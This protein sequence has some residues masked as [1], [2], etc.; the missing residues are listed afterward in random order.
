MK[1]G[2]E[3]M[4]FTIRK[5]AISIIV[6]LL[7]FMGN[8]NGL[9]ASNNQPS[10][11]FQV[12]P[13]QSVIVKPVNENARGNLD[14]S[15]IPKGK[16]TNTFRDPIDVVFIFDKSGSMDANRMK[17]AK[18]AMKVA[19]DYFIENAHY[20]DRFALVPFSS[21]VELNNVVSFDPKWTPQ[22]S[23]QEIN[24]KVQNL[25][26]LGGTNYTSSFEKASEIL[27]AGSN[28]KYIIFLTD[29]E[30]TV[31]KN[32]EKYACK[33][34][35]SSTCE[36]PV[37]Q[38]LYGSNPS[39]SK[40][41]AYTNSNFST[42]S[43][44]WDSSKKS[45][46]NQ[47]L[48]VIR[49]DGIERAKMLANN[50][51]K[52]YS[53]GFGNNTEFDIG[54]L[55][56]L[57]QLTGANARQATVENIATILKNISESIDRPSISGEVHIDL[58]KYKD[59]VSISEDANVR[60][61]NNIAKI[62]FNFD[63]PLNEQAPAPRDLALP[64]SF[65]DVGLYKF[66][67]IKLIYKNLDGQQ[68]WKEHEPV[69]IEVKAE[70]PPTFIGSMELLK[71]VNDIEELIKQ[72]DQTKRTNEFSVK[73]EL[74]PTGLMDKQVSGKLTN[75]KIIQPLP[76]GIIPAQ[77][78]ETTPYNGQLAIVIQLNDVSYQKGTF[79]PN[80]LTKQVK[81][82]ADWAMSNVTMP[83]AI[84]QYKDNRFGDQSTSITPSTQII[85]MKFRLFDTEMNR[86][87][88]G[89]SGGS[90]SKVVTGQTTTELGRATPDGDKLK[91]K[92]IKEMAFQPNSSDNV[93]TITYYDNEKVNIYLTP[94]FSMT[95]E[96]TKK[97]YSDGDVA[98]EFV[99]VNVSQQ[100]AGDHV[101]YEYYVEN[102]N[103]NSSVWHPL[104]LN[105][106]LLV[107]E[108][109][110]NKVIVKAIGG[111]AR[112]NSNIQKT[113]YIE[114]VIPIK[115]VI[116][117]PNPIEIEVDK[118]KKFSLEVVPKEATNQ[119]LTLTIE[120]DQYS[121]FDKEEKTRLH[122]IKPGETNMI[123]R[124]YDKN[125]QVVFE[126]KVPVKVIDPY[127]K[128]E[129]IQFTKPLYKI[130]VGEMLPIDDSVIIFNPYD[131]TNKEIVTI[132]S[133]MSN[134][135]EVRKNNGKWYV[136]GVE[137]GYSTITATAEKQN[138][139]TQPKDS[140]LFEVVP[141]SNKNEGPK[142]AGRW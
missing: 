137:I 60:V 36:G 10:I 97:A 67:Q 116:V 142:G 20:K 140:T 85:N 51:I 29:G 98:Y 89:T 61:E 55:R 40:A 106:P 34:K 49:N 83:R 42:S 33:N 23:L 16:A 45:D 19:T 24:R 114:E 94:D 44:L 73:Y 48:N 139:G 52:M 112:E 80:Q 135:V 43:K 66:D 39:Y 53:I 125:K 103:M 141:V 91:S 109:G 17:A 7:V 92:P 21:D 65:S 27:S 128:L 9:A 64:L 105:N 96:N 14:I 122:G 5:F 130:K 8:M 13:S 69:T 76:A 25:L 100:V 87:Y 90:I 136:I 1:G 26:A 110:E 126:K 113:I 75:I 2:N 12:E 62:K 88:D 107:S 30:P 104:D 134:K 82:K 119:K 4:V 131:A 35:K 124:Q 95:G 18:N 101:T 132:D 6:I 86:A 3:S 93:I 102:E 72:A 120:D 58:S 138:D 71:E 99:H 77:D 123:I 28:D 133:S 59:K 56:E 108:Y 37:F 121:K 54:Y 15:L 84:V 115:D 47:V 111:L 127:V 117:D 118:S 32:I 68:V 78:V 41:G 31:T 81:L 129:N 57:S 79:N 46:I 22:Q 50:N 63:F 74:K 11:D 38:V 70:A